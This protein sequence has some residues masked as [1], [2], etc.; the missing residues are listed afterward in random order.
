MDLSEFKAKLER[1]REMEVKAVGATFRL[2]LPSEHA[3]RVAAEEHRGPGGRVKQ[4]QASRALLEASVL[5]WEGVT[6]GHLLLDGSTEP[7]SFSVEALT[8]LLNE[9][10]DIADELSVALMKRVKERAAQVETA[11]K[12]SLRAP[13]GISTVKQ[14]ARS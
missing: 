9:R 7:V 6:E 8:M 5:G 11:R 10:Q 2:R 12:N 4:E 13:S 1:A 14:A 3:W